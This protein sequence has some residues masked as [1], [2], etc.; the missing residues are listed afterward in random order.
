MSESIK[1][2]LKLLK[3]LYF[4]RNYRFCV[5]VLKSDRAKYWKWGA[6]VKGSTQSWPLK[7]D[8][9]YKIVFIFLKYKFKIQMQIY[10]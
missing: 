2:H 8:Q 7:N 10:S 6:W 9:I 1:L 4:N 3:I 5:E